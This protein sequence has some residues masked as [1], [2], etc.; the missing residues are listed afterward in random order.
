[1][2]RQF[3]FFC[4]LPYAFLFLGRLAWR[5]ESP[6][7]LLTR[8]KT[9]EALKVLG[10]MAKINGTSLPEGELA[11]IVITKPTSNGVASIISSGMVIKTMTV[12][13]LFFFQ[14]FSY[15]GLTTWL[16][17]FATIRGIKNLDPI[18]AFLVIGLSELP[19]LA[20]TTLLI[21]KAGRRVVLIMNFCGSALCSAL[22]LFVETRGAFLAVSSASYF[23]IVGCWA[24]IYISTPELF[25]TTCRA[26]AFAIAGAV[27]KLAGIL[28]PH[29]FG[30]IWDNKLEP[31]I[32]VSTVSG[33]FLIAALTGIFLMVETSGRCLTDQ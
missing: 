25:P 21:E 22:L 11:P 26:T 33:G 32:A 17:N 18:H 4:G 28:S 13:V 20:L 23:F 1:V 29:I 6:R 2:W 24:A 27:G 10:V 14:T 15:Y 7:F 5:W 19:G 12:S 3:V 30:Y 8:Q 31:W 9:S 16:R